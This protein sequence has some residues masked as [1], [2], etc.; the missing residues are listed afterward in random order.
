LNVERGAVLERSNEDGDGAA[1]AED[2]A[3]TSNPEMGMSTAEDSLRGGVAG[4]GVNEEDAA[5]PTP[6]ASVCVRVSRII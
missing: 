5:A 2:D 4:M 1:A 3:A 6:L